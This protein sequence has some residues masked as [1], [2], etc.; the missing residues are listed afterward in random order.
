MRLFFAKIECLT[1]S[2]DQ[3]QWNPYWTT[4]RHM[5]PLVNLTMSTECDYVLFCKYLIGVA[6]LP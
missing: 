5:I 4:T 6:G 1:C 2:R 3:T